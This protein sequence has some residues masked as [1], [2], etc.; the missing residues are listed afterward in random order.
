MSAPYPSHQK[1]LDHLMKYVI[2]TKNRGLV[3]S[4]DRIWDGSKDFE[5][6]IHGKSD[7]DYAMN[8]N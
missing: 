4:P 5:F 6:H 8:D 3:L 7:P 1:A 2:S